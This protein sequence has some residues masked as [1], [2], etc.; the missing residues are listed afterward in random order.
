MDSANPILPPDIEAAVDLEDSVAAI[1]RSLAEAAAG[2]MRDIDDVFD[3]LDAR[4]AT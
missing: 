2:Q 1:K 3:D 4:Y